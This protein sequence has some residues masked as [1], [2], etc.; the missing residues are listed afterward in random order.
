MG[1]GKGEGGLCWETQKMC[2]G[3][4]AAL[5]TR[6]QCVSAGVCFSMFG[7]EGVISYLARAVFAGTCE[8]LNAWVSRHVDQ[9]CCRTHG[10]AEVK[11]QC[12]VCVKSSRHSCAVESP[13]LSFPLVEFSD[14]GQAVRGALVVEC[15]AHEEQW[16]GEHRQRKQEQ[17]TQKASTEMQTYSPL[18]G[19]IRR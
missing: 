4:G 2:D 13:A 8:L 18:A 10:D 5:P 17:E 9:R 7:Q 14:D 16:Q 15:A 12:T 3:E 11:S 6:V 19:H 1:L